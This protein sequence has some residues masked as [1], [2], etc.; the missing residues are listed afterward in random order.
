MIIHNV[1]V[2]IKIRKI[3]LLC[4]FISILINLLGV[5][6]RF[7]YLTIIGTPLLIIYILLSLLFWKC[8]YCKKRLPMR[9]N[10]KD[11]DYINDID[12]SYCCPWCNTRI[13]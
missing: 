12:E 9:F 2:L 11:S 6:L 1:K 13:Y 3:S 7:G 5:L 8:P 4:L 10:I